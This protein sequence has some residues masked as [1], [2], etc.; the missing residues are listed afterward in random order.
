MGMADP[1]DY[2]DRRYET[3]ENA[4]LPEAPVDALKGF[5][6]AAARPCARSSA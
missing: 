3:A 5:G 4:E 6:K 2:L 1:R